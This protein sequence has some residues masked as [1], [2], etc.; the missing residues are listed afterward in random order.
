VLRRL[1]A[2]PFRAQLRKTHLPRLRG[3]G[4][5]LDW[6]ATFPGDTWQRR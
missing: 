1:D 2:A 6:L 4:K 5:F 3:A